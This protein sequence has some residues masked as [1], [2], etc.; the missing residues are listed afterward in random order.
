MWA[1]NARPRPLYP[2]EKPGN[3]YIGGWM[4]TQGRS[5]RVRKIATPTGIQSADSPARS[6]SLYR[7]SY[8]GA[9]QTPRHTLKF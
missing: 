7:L 6:K 3:P 4:G 8:P 9:D 1:V 2:R 5:G